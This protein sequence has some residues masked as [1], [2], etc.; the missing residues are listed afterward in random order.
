MDTET[1]HSGAWKGLCREPRPWLSPHFNEAQGTRPARV[2]G[3]PPAPLSAPHKSRRLGPRP[4]A[5]VS[6]HWPRVRGG[7][8]TPLQPWLKQAIA[9][10]PPGSFKAPRQHQQVG[11][12]VSLEALPTPA[13]PPT[14][15]PSPSLRTDHTHSV[16]SL[17]RGQVR[18]RGRS[19]QTCSG[20]S[21][22]QASDVT[23]SPAPA[24]P[25]QP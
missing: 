9:Q 12:G 18:G 14:L 6:R 3:G 7:F 22:L 10:A 20:P 15:A 21:P 4:S 19:G 23:G 8:Q 16:P 13:L 2:L 1:G 17:P 24:R 5:G 25:Q 11:P